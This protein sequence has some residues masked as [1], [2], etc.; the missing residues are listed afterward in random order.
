[1][2]G[3]EGTRLPVHEGRRL[4]PTSP[5][6]PRPLDEITARHGEGS[7]FPPGGGSVAGDGPVQNRYD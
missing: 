5:A 2:M 4:L 1:M 3:G 6:M 7:F